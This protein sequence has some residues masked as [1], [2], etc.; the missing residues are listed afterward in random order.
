MRPFPRVLLLLTSMLAVLFIATDAW[1]RAGGG[2]GYSGGGGGS[3]GSGGGGGGGEIIFQLIRL[4]IYLCRY[5]PIIGIPLTIAIIVG[6]VYFS[7]AGMQK[8]QGAYQ[9]RVIRRA[10][11]QRENQLVE[12]GISRISESDPKF[13]LSSF[14]DRASGAFIKIQD[15]WS[16][17]DL[18]SIRSFV[19][20]G[21][22]ERFKLQITEQKDLGYRNVMENVRTEMVT[23][24][25][26][27][28]YEPFDEITLRI[29]ASA[30]DYRVGLADN[31]EISG[32]RRDESFAEYWSFI[33]RRGAISF[34]G[35][36]L[37]EGFC[38]N[39]GDEIGINQSAKCT[40]CGSLL[41]SG[42][43][44]WVL[45]EITQACEWPPPHDGLPPGAH[46][47]REKFDPTFNA[48]HLEDRA[49]VIFWRKC[50]AD[51]TGSVDPLR[52]CALPDFCDSYSAELVGGDSNDRTYIGDCA[53]GAVDAIGVLHNKPFDN[54]LVVVHWSGR[55]FHHGK[56]RWATPHSSSR[57]HLFV[58]SRKAG[59][60]SSDDYAISSL[61]CPS[62][63]APESDLASNNCDYCGATLGD[64]SMD[65]S[66]SAIYSIN[67][68]TAQQLI[69]EAKRREGDYYSEAEVIDIDPRGAALMA[70]SVKMALS[71]HELDA[72][73]EKIIRRTAKGLQMKDEQID[74]MIAAA[75][76]EE[77]EVPQPRDAKE[78]SRWLTEM[79][80]I[81]LSDGRVDRSEATLLRQAGE[82]FGLSKAD[83]NLLFNRRRAE[84]YQRAKRQ[85][86][87]Q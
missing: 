41:R 72:K 73:E 46:E 44:D 9:G 62:C 59:V 4:L 2:G 43:Y 75:K 35:D 69:A 66:L 26:V 7:R 20:D 25:R 76:A 17:Q 36:G 1:A 37:L 64:G 42:Q 12:R 22:Y 86:A 78:G 48:Q 23:A 13:S 49:S 3:G 29:E 84:L 24:C 56:Q 11:T 68:T 52:K 67:D 8:G 85:R 38:P 54:V 32:Y 58:L 77:L 5:Q 40:T 6:A 18:Q 74:E 80:D 71:N 83:V 45:S 30:T 61:H 14:S 19:S 10:N 79:I 55:E 51:R 63:G 65:W 57:R 31:R 82:Q 15:A 47:Y 81:A 70:W 50:M 16:Q 87:A 33:R 34:D 21:I 27:V 53:V 28:C 60:R 39:C